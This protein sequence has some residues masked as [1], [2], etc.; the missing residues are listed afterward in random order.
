M[1]KYLIDSDAWLAPRKLSVLAMMIDAETLPRPLLMGEY[2]ARHEL[3]SISGELSDLE[4]HSH[5]RVC[6]VQE[7]V[8]KLSPRSATVTV[9]GYF[10]TLSFSKNRRSNPALQNGSDS[11]R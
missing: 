1:S 4:L 11:S 6:G 8:K 3:S 7:R 10:L 5:L 2:A 9:S